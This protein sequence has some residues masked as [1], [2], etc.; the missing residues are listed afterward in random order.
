MKIC[1]LIRTLVDLHSMT[2]ML[3]NFRVSAF[4]ELSKLPPNILSTTRKKWSKIRVTSS[5]SRPL[6]N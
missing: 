6:S 2:S 3:V 4:A 5:P 1:D